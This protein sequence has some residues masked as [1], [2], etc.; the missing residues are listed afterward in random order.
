MRQIAVIGSYPEEFLTH[1]KAADYTSSVYEMFSNVR[2]LS[3]IH[4]SLNVNI[5]YQYLQDSQGMPTAVA[6]FGANACLESTDAINLVKSNAILLLFSPPIDLLQSIKRATKTVLNLAKIKLAD[7]VPLIIYRSVD[8]IP[9]FPMLIDHIA[10][11]MP[12][13]GFISSLGSLLARRRLAIL[14]YSNTLLNLSRS[15]LPTRAR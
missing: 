10:V 4:F 8:I 9:K 15:A 1:V 12:L 3:L 2:C 5:H 6:V 14:N 11:C 13:I 7:G